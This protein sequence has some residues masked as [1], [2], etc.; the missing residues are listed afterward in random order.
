MNIIFIGPRG[1]G[2]SK[3]SRALSKRID[4]PVVSTD[5]IIVYENGGMPIPKYVESNSWKA[6]R[7]LEY[8]ILKKLE[9]AD[10]IILDCGGGILFDLDADGNEILS[11][12]K[13]NILKKLGRIILLERDFKELLEKVEGDKTRPD[14]AKNK[15]YSEILKKRL[16]F[17]ENV[18][19]FKLNMSTLSK[20]EA[21]D[22]ITN[23]L[24]I[25]S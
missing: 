16:P 18:S 14:L 23:R 19:H 20:E 7:D 17:Y 21:V 5:S 25:H 13:L 15:A 1:A 9:H 2:K 11:E 12:R 8:S 4:Y 22:Q 10:G 24:G 6:F 3:V